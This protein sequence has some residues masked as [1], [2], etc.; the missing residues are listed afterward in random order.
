MKGTQP[1]SDGIGVETQECGSRGHLSEI[2][3]E[4]FNGSVGPALGLI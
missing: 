4:A 3:Q 2:S 1:G